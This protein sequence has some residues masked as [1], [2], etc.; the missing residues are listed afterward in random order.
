MIQWLFIY[1]C[2]IFIDYLTIQTQ[3]S[4]D[5]VVFEACKALCELKNISNKDLQPTVSVLCL[6]LLS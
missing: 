2:K 1:F 5:A 4:Q 3:K 6:F